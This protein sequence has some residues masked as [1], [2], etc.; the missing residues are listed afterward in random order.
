M[1]QAMKVLERAVGKRLREML[2]SME[3][4]LGFVKGKETTYA[5]WIMRQIQGFNART[6]QQPILCL[7]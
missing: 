5:I 4:T 6:K 7:C 1:E 2:T 3:Y